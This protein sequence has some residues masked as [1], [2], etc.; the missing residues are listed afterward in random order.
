MVP[1]VEN[2]LVLSDLHFGKFF[3][4]KFKNEAYLRELVVN[5]LEESNIK[6]DVILCPGDLTSVGNETEFE[7]ATG[8]LHS[9]LDHWSL[10]RRSLVALVGNHDVNWEV[11]KTLKTSTA[12]NL[13]RHLSSNVQS[14][15]HWPQFDIP[16][17]VYGTGVVDRGEF[18]IIAFNSSW[19][20][21]DDDKK[22]GEL[23]VKQ[24]E[25]LTGLAAGPVGKKPCIVTLHHHPEP[26]PYPTSIRSIIKDLS[27]VSD[28]QEFLHAC[29]NFNVQLIVHGHRHHPALVNIMTK[30]AVQKTIPV[31][32]AGSLSV[33]SKK[34][35]SDVP[36]FFHLIHYSPHAAASIVR[37]F[38]STARG[39][40]D[41]KY[42]PDFHE[43]IN[44]L[45]GIPGSAY[46]SVDVTGLHAELDLFFES[47]K[48]LN[49]D[50]VSPNLQC[51]NR[52]EMMS[53]VQDYAKKNGRRVCGEYFSENGLMLI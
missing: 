11:H 7:Q 15:Y 32:C 40:W 25:W 8:F 31:L 1:H 21:L 13:A 23:G 5:C 20:C 14:C 46:S 26:I 27:Q 4:P 3:D 38:N 18:T 45:Q 34:R 36:N 24:I 17:P 41:S 30:G 12:E 53:I 39:V 49:F 2:I 22:N 52:T 37:T 44:P 28:G 47:A 35:L 51:K 9:L 50:A 33:E 19:N 42:N 16:G 48:P 29:S 6:P 10:D 43:T